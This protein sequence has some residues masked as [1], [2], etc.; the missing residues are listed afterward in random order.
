[1]SSQRS[2]LEG[3]DHCSWQAEALLI[4]ATCSPAPGLGARADARLVWG[5]FG[6]PWLGL[7]VG[8]R[9][10]WLPSPEQVITCQSGQ[11]T[12]RGCRAPLR[13]TVSAGRESLAEPPNWGREQAAPQVLLGTP[14]PLWQESS[15]ACMMRSLIFKLRKSW[16]KLPSS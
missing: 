4:A 5:S 7:W 8:R 14:H 13:A 3:A 2:T 11:A 9:R 10:L 16:A 6:C 1:M 12:L 15:S